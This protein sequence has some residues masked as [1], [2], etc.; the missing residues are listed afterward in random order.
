MDFTGGGMGVPTACTYSA[1]ITC[2]GDPLT[3]IKDALLG[4]WSG[5][6]LTPYEP[7]YPVIFTFD[8]YTHYSAKATDGRSVAL[9]WGIDA[10]SP[11]KQYDI[12][13]VSDSGEASGTID[14]VEG[15]SV[16][17]SRL[18]RIVLTTELNELSFR[19]LHN[20]E[21]YQTASF[22]LQRVL[23]APAGH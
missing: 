8:S 14:I 9:F 7:S 12:N 3:R 1:E 4:T 23:S 17:R 13:E 19:F 10:D 18:E 5:T 22:H 20:N 2:S 11:L 21:S 15:T 6:A 16:F